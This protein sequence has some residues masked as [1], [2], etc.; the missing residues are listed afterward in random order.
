MDERFEHV[1]AAHRLDAGGIELRLPE[2]APVSQHGQE[3]P[4]GVVVPAGRGIGG[5]VRPLTRG[6]ARRYPVV[7]RVREIDLRQDF[8]HGSAARLYDSDVVLCV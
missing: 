4:P 3:D 6:S 1:E 7:P 2:T 5:G 8:D